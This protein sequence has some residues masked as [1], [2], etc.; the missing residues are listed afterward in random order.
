VSRL[1]DTGLQLAPG[2]HLS[3]QRYARPQG[4]A[5]CEPPPASLGLLPLAE[6][7]DGELLLPL[8]QDEAFWIG[9]AAGPGEAPMRLELAVQRPDGGSEAAPPVAV[10][11]FGTVAG[12]PSAQGGL[13]A[14]TRA[15]ASLLRLAAWREGADRP[16]GEATL[17]VVD[18]ERFTQASGR[19]APAPLD[20]R[21]G[22]RGW[23]LP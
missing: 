16:E 8:A 15:T 12:W 10:G 19:P 17:Q 13:Q 4:D 22:Y 11:G 21:A 6:G 7:V 23:R 20:P 18:C 3:F 1:D 9:L 14:F 5:A 2:L